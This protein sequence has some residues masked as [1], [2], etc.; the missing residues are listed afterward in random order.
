MAPDLRGRLEKL[1]ACVLRL[2]E[3]RARAPDAAA[4]AANPDLVDIVERNFHLAVEALLDVAAHAAAARGLTRPDTGGALFD[5]LSA[6]GCLTPEDAAAGHRWVGFRNVLVH[7]YADLDRAVV[8]HVLRN[9]LDELKSLA[10]AL[11]RLV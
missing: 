3:M 6:A 7:Q 5:V 2:E 4:F 8:F 1:R 10:S 9:E 11:A